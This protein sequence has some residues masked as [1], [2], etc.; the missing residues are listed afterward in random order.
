LAPVG[1]PA[2]VQLAAQ[3]ARAGAR[4][5]DPGGVRDGLDRAA[6]RIDRQTRDRPPDHHFTFDARKLE[7]Y[8]ATAL[9]WSGDPAGEDIARDVVDRY[10]AGPPRR[11]ATARI[12]LGLILARAGRPD[13][14]A[15][16]GM[17]AAK[18]GRLVPSNR[19]R[20]TELDAALADRRDIPEV[21]ELHER[22]RDGR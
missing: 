1:S 9:A 20:V 19:W 2:A 17:L 16:L 7:T 10:V 3:T 4:L 11:L 14:A 15:A 12:D 6:A 5:D 13:E 21:A 18:S 8:T 22:V